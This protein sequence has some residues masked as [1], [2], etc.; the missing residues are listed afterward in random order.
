MISAHVTKEQ[1]ANTHQVASGIL[2]ELLVNASQRPADFAPTNFAFAG[3]AVH[4]CDQLE[5]HFL[6]L[7]VIHTIQFIYWRPRAPTY[8]SR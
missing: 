3:A 6:K 1:L 2:T 5:G 4:H 8:P 7:P